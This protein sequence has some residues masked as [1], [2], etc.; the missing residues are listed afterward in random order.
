MPSPCHRASAHSR[1]SARCCRQNGPFPGRIPRSGWGRA[2]DCPGPSRFSAH[3]CAG[4]APRPETQES[5]YLRHSPPS[6]RFSPAP[7]PDP[8]CGASF[9]ILHK[10]PSHSLPFHPMIISRPRANRN[11]WHAYALEKR[12]FP[13]YNAAKKERDGKWRPFVLPR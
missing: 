13:S 8:P 5:R 9:C 3:P 6:L 12:P 11:I 10:C 4:P 1:S 2:A 7:P